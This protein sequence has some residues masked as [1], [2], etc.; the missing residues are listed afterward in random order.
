MG[1][2]YE[3][4]LY[5]D[6]LRKGVLSSPELESKI[7]VATPPEFKNGMAGIWSPEH[8]FIASISSC[9][10]TTFLAI[11]ENSNFPFISLTVSASGKLEKADTK[12]LFREILLSPRLT[13]ENPNDQ[14]RALRILQKSE[15]ACLITNSILTKVI[16]QPVIDLK[17]PLKTQVK[18]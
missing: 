15:S 17:S 3:V 7:E 18:Q 12:L 1:H 10:M 8:L 11:A 2:N 6:K 16:L 13:I 14:E 5:W 4:N 9:F